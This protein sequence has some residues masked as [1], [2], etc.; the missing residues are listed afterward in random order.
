V[1]AVA[2]RFSARDRFSMSGSGKCKIPI[3]IDRN[4]NIGIRYKP[5]TTKPVTTPTSGKFVLNMPASSDPDS[6]LHSHPPNPALS[7]SVHRLDL[8][9]MLPENMVLCRLADSFNTGE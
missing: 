9:P 6:I 4:P 7:V 5:V 3:I 2:Q 8:S 1:N